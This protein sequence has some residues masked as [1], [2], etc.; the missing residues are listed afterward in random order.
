VIAID[1]DERR[2]RRAQHLL[3]RRLRSR[4]WRP[5]ASDPNAEPSARPRAALVRA[6]RQRRP[7]NHRAFAATRTTLPHDAKRHLAL[8]Q[9]FAWFDP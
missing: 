2:E 6:H 8:N 3:D 7:T 4:A 1:G 9:R 5:P